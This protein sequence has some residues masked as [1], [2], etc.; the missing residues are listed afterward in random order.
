[1][2]YAIRGCVCIS[3]EYARALSFY[4]VE[5]YIQELSIIVIN[6]IQVYP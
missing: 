1:M 6:I 4:F 5:R 3:C 2:V